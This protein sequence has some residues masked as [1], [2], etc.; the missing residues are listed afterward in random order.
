MTNVNPPPQP[1]IPAKFRDDPSVL[2]YLQQIQ[3]IIFQLWERTGGGDDDI[4]DFLDGLNQFDSL[5]YLSEINGR[6][7][8]NYVST[9][10]NYTAL[11]YDFAIA[12]DELTVTLP[13][14]PVDQSRVKVKTTVTSSVTIDGNGKNVDGDSNVVI[15]QDYVLIDMIYTVETD[16]WL[17]I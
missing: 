17:I 15:V 3:F 12:S 14:E 7:E 6:P 13:S 2:D 1:P 9:S 11:D 10:S 8:F 5:N 16:E 4:S